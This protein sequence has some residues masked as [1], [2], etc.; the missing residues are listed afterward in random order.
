MP[1]MSPSRSRPS[2]STAQAAARLEL[3]TALLS[4]RD[5]AECAQLAVDWLINHITFSDR[6]LGMYLTKKLPA[7]APAHARAAAS[8]ARPAA[9]QSRAVDSSPAAPAALQWNDA[10]STSIGEIDTFSD[11]VLKAI[12]TGIAS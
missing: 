8:A 11:A 2:T 3:T 4:S 6:A 12:K 10:L 5:P 1:V 7:D 9:E